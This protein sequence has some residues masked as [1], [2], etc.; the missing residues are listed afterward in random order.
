LGGEMVEATGNVANPVEGRFIRVRG[1]GGGRSGV[2][3]SDGRV[4]RDRSGCIGY[5]S[6]EGPVHVL[7]EGR[8]GQQQSRQRKTNLLHGSP[9]LF[10]GNAVDILYPRFGPSSRA[11]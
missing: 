5:D 7:A 2:A 10:P 11:G 6:G 9:L 8:T 1:E 4:R 3:G